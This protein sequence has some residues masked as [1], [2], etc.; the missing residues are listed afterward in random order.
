MA[1]YGGFFGAVLEGGLH[2]AG[3]FGFHEEEFSESFVG[4]VGYYVKELVEVEV[5]LMVFGLVEVVWFFG[6]VLDP[7]YINMFYYEVFFP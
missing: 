7:G 6:R 5:F 1:S 4:F 3:V 2:E